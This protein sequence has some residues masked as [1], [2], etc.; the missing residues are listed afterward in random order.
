VLNNLAQVEQRLGQREAAARHQFLA[1]E[2]YHRN[3]DER[4]YVVA[5]NNLAELYAELGLLPEAEEHARQGVELA[6]GGSMQ[7]EEAF[8][9]QVLGTVLAKRGERVAAQAELA[10]SLRLFERLGSTRSM[11]VRTALEALTS[12]V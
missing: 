7:F 8:G 1:M 2:I 11:L 10:E 3:G 5:V 6:R 4:A 12:E 9:R